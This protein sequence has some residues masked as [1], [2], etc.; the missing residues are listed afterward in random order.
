SSALSP[1]PAGFDRI[2][3]SDAALAGPDNGG[4]ARIDPDLAIQRR[5]VVADRVVRELQTF[6]H[7]EVGLALADKVKHVPLTIRQ[8][9]QISARC[10][11]AG[12]LTQRGQFFHDAATEP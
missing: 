7:V 12:R 3:A 8:V 10:R 11:R 1:R 2:L 5:K 6:A 9:L 4:G